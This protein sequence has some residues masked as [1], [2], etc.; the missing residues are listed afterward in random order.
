MDG[1]LPKDYVFSVLVPGAIPSTPC[2]P[3]KDGKIYITERN[4]L[5]GVGHQV[6]ES[7]VATNAII[8]AATAYTTPRGIYVVFKGMAA[9]QQNGMGS[10]MVTTAD[11]RDEALAWSVATEGDN[12]FHGFDGDTGQVLFA[13]EARRMLSALFGA[14][15]RPSSPTAGSTW[16]RTAQ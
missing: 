8:N 13:A 15:T 11:G 10:P 14:F 3:R 4:D 1:E 12:R 16:R 9:T 7:K 6:S 5:G 2:R